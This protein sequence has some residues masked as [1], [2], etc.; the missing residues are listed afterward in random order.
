MELAKIEKLLDAYFEGNTSLAEEA[1]LRDYFLQDEVAP[2]LAMYQPMFAGLA[3]AKQ[4]VSQR[5]IHLPQRQF[6]MKNWWYG[7]AA[8][9]VI[10]IGVAG[11]VFSEPNNHLTKEEQEAL[12]AFEKTREAMQLMSK[13]FN[14]GAEELTHISTFTQTKNRILK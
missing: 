9:V 8:S 7:V 12:V 3:A 10:A 11:F 1:I 5:E 6:K 4:E 13:N 14:Q 2:H